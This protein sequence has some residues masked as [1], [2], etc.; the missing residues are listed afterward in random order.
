MNL[1]LFNQKRNRD[2]NEY[3]DKLCIS[4]EDFL[5]INSN[6]KK[7]L[8]V[9]GGNSTIQEYFAKKTKMNIVNVDFDPPQYSECDRIRNIKAD[10]VADCD[11]KDEFDEIW[12]LYSLPL[13]SPS[14]EMIYKYIL[15]AL[16]ALK[17][18]GV[19]RFF[20]IEYDTN[21]KLKTKDA[22]YDMATME[23]TRTVLKVLDSIKEYGVEVK[24]VRKEK[25]N[26]NRIE[27]TVILTNKFEIEKKK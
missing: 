4:T 24:R 3:L 8:L 2:L 22:D 14:K 7:I 9:G 27:E 26:I 16:L 21:E 20:P 10:F 11:Y 17:P 25:Q 13:Y 6:E 19:F 12:A 5:S 1:Y 23:N 18:E 15:K